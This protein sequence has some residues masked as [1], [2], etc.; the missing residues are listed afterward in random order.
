[1]INKTFLIA[2]AILAGL[3]VAIGAFGS[4]GLK[5]MLT[6]TQRLDTFEIAVKYQFYHALGLLIIGIL[7][8]HMPGRFID[9]SGWFILAGTFIFSG[10]LYVLCLTNYSFLGAITPQGGLAFIIGRGLLLWGIIK[11]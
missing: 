1:M 9:L 11:G 3:A 6:R 2:G 5:E 10:S 4:H 7:Q 8:I